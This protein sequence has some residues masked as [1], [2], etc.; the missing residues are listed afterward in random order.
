MQLCK[1]DIDQEN[2]SPVDVPF[3]NGSSKLEL[4]KGWRTIVPEGVE[5]IAQGTL[6]D[7]ASGISLYRDELQEK[8]PCTSGLARRWQKQIRS[9][10]GRVL[11]KPKPR[12]VDY[13]IK[14][15]LH[16]FANLL[17]NFGLSCTAAALRRRQVEE[18]V[19]S[20]ML[21]FD[22]N[23]EGRPCNR[24]RESGDSS[25]DIALYNFI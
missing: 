22:Q 14:L 24:P 16:P 9:E 8:W 3:H 11:L 13:P 7:T 19:V 1:A 17:G 20:E 12:K 25:L 6:E 23:W 2:P 18:S 4:S 21:L 10:S 15:H 5:V